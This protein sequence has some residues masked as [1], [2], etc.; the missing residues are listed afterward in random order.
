MLAQL[1]GKPVLKNVIALL[2]DLRDAGFGASL[3]ERLSSSRVEEYF[4]DRILGSIV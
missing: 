2:M 3:C 1:Y 4:C